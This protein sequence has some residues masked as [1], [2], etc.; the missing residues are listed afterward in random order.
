MARSK[1]KIDDSAL[2]KVAEQATRKLASDLTR[3]LNVLTPQYQGRPLDEVKKAVAETWSRHS[4]GG[5]ITDPEL[6]KFAEQIAAGGQVTV[7]AA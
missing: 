2:R 6:T 5:S 7:N 4:G 1:L 3:A